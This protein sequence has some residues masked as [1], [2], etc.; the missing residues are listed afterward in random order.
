[1]AINFAA[2]M[3][4]KL[5]WS[6]KRWKND[7]ESSRTN[8]EPPEWSAFAEILER[9][10]PYLCYKRICLQIHFCLKFNTVAEQA[11]HDK[12]FCKMP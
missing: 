9:G 5:V 1:M 4:K 2:G 10:L 7:H 12:F 11:Q 3:S 6:F 8:V